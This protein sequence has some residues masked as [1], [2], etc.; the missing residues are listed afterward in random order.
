[1]FPSKFSTGI[2]PMR[3]VYFKGHSHGKVCEIIALNNS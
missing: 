2:Y 1:M 3:T